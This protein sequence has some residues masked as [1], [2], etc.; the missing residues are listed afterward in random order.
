MNLRCMRVIFYLG[1]VLI[2]F[3]SE[4]RKDKT[5][6]YAE[7]VMVIA[8]HPDDD[9]LGCGGT[10]QRY[11][12]DGSKVIA[13]FMT[14]GGGKAKEK[15][16]TTD[17]LCSIRE[18]EATR[19][20]AILGVADLIFLNE[21][22]RKLSVTDNRI[23]CVVD[24]LEDRRPDIIFI[25]HEKDDHKDHKATYKI[26]ERAVRKLVNNNSKVPRVLCYEVWTPLQQ[27]TYTQSIGKYIDKKLEAL[28]EHVSQITYVNYVDSIQALNRYRGIARFAGSYAECFLELK[29]G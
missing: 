18:E 28:K 4:A 7:T 3:E 10:I 8:P 24:L 22:D 15:N 29:I 5:L 19:A 11:L 13:V 14:S 23:A 27:I 6:P 1:M 2:S 20:L 17:E 26:V 16:M 9:L 21:P 12:D 25:P